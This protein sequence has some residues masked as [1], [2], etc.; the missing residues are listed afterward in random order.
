MNILV[1][2]SWFL[3]SLAPCMDTANFDLSYSESFKNFM[4]THFSHD[5]KE[6]QE[7]KEF[8]SDTYFL[9]IPGFGSDFSVKYFKVGYFR[10]AQYFLKNTLG[11]VNNVDYEYLPIRSQRPPKENYAQIA[12]AIL[13][14]PLN[15]KVLIIGHSKGALD[16]LH[17]LVDKDQEP[18]LKI[19]LINKLKGY[20]SIQGPLKG[21]VLADS[22]S[23]SKISRLIF[24]G[25]LKLTG[26][27]YESLANF[28][29]KLN[30]EFIKD[31]ERELN[32]LQS[33][34]PVVT[35]VSTTEYQ[36]TTSM[37]LLI[38]FKLLHN[39]ID[40]PSNDTLVNIHRGHL[41]GN[42]VIFLNGIDHTDTV[43][44]FG[45]RINRIHFFS[46]LL[47][48]FKEI[49]KEHKIFTLI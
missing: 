4:N 45:K 38:P 32:E 6:I 25:L 35:F 39:K 3:I 15:K 5:L 42:Y 28:E 8:Y 47:H 19:A 31:H 43:V 12:K 17:A 49:Y 1:A 23:E 22:I 9:L 18:D 24:T 33:R 20:F 44:N 21:S 13:R 30:E 11:L 26:G 37:P 41:D 14:A 40:G 2:F 7:L 36:K 16:S 27:T 10:E 48:S 29:T 46:A 34:I